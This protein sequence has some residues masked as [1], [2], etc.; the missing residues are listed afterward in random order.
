MG[1]NLQPAKYQGDT[2]SHL[3]DG[4]GCADTLCERIALVVP[5][6]GSDDLCSCA[7]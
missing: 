3:L 6:R 1:G 2:W 7:S 5:R 4:V